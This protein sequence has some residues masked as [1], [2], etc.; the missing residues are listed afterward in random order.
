MSEAQIV[1]SH[2]RESGIVSSPHSTWLTDG[3]IFLRQARV[4]TPH[5]RPA[6]PVAAPVRPFAVAHPAHRSH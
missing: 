2:S 5:C 6:L 1:L 4:S 3:E